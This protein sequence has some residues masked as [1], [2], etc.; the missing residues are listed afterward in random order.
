MGVHTGIDVCWDDSGVFISQFLIIVDVVAEF[1]EH[2]REETGIINTEKEFDVRSFLGEGMKKR[3]KS[4]VDPYDTCSVG[5][6][7][8]IDL[9]GGEPYDRWLGGENRSREISGF[10]LVWKFG[11]G[12][13]FLVSH[14][15]LDH[16]AGDSHFFGK[17]DFLEFTCDFVFGL[18]ADGASIKNNDICL[19]DRF[20]RIKTT[21]FE[22]RFDSGGVGIVHLAT[23]GNHVEFHS[24]FF[25]IKATC[26]LWIC[27]QK[28]KRRSSVD[29]L[30]VRL[31]ILV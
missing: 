29:L 15:M 30:F 19:S 10:E 12:A 13:D 17:R 2:K 7:E 11:S 25:L 24:V 16:T 20:Y 4:M 28:S 5:F 23:Q 18:L 26:I 21:I 3:I 22:N 27:S 6:F 31:I 8:G 1:L 9:F 14:G